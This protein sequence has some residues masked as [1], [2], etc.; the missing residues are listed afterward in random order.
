VFTYIGKKK[1]DLDGF[2]KVNS[3]KSINFSKI[4]KEDIET[5]VVDGYE[6]V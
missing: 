2:Q 4:F 6:R 1:G 5:A 3:T